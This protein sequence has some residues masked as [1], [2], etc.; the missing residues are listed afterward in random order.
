MSKKGPKEH[1]QD[2]G[3]TVH[4]WGLFE[5]KP[6]GQGSVAQHDHDT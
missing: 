1:N 3:G 5:G 6:S 4:S 2:P